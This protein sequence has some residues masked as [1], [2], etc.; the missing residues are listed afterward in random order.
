MFIITLVTYIVEQFSGDCHPRVPDSHIKMPLK[1]TKWAWLKLY[2][3]IPLQTKDSPAALKG[4]RP[5]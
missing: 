5:H 2:V 1:G 4:R 3:T